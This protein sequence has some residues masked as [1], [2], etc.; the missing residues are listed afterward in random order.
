MGHR[1]GTL[2]IGVRDHMGELRGEGD[3]LIVALCHRH[4]KLS[5]AAGLK[6]LSRVCDVGKAFD[7]FR[8]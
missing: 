1:H 5:E 8:D 7:L 4:R 2:D 6:Y 3:D